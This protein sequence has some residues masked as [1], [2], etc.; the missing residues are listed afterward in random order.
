M[1][2]LSPEVATP[3][4]LTATAPSDRPGERMLDL[5]HVWVELRADAADGDVAAAV[6]GV[7]RV[8]PE[9]AGDH[10]RAQPLARPAGVDRQARRALDVSGLVV[11]HAPPA[12]AAAG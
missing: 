4:W 8:Q 7:A 5:D 10:V 3:P 9:V 6:D 1:R 12:S 11:D 2:T